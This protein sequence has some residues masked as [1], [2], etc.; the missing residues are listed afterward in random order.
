MAFANWALLEFEENPH[1]LLSILW[2]DE[3]H[4]LL[5]GIVNIVKSGRTNMYAQKNLYMHHMLMFGVVLPQKFLWFSFP[6]KSL[7]QD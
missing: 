1:W 2:T 4:F 3:A 5:H 7:V 6:L